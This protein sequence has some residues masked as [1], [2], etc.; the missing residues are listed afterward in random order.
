MLGHLRLNFA[1][2]TDKQEAGKKVAMC[3]P[4]GPG[5]K[6]RRQSEGNPADTWRQKKEEID[7]WRRKTTRKQEKIRKTGQT[8]KKTQEK[9][10]KKQEKQ[11]NPIRGQSCRHTAAK[12]RRDWQLTQEKHKKT[13]KHKKNRAKTQEKQ[14]NPRAKRYRQLTRMVLVIG[15]FLHCVFKCV[16]REDRARKRGQSC[17]HAQWQKQEEIDTDGDWEQ[18]LLQVRNFY[19][20]H[21]PRRI[22]TFLS[23]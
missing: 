14:G 1:R 11:G 3:C 2:Q 16:A 9:Q 19:S 5:K 6:T 21:S 4:R 10:G 13:R 20:N 8:N 23:F 12:E 18:K 15:T 22:N 17:R 7:S